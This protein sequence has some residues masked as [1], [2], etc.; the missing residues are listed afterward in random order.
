M[1]CGHQWP[2]SLSS[3]P[4]SCAFSTLARPTDNKPSQRALFLLLFRRFVRFLY[5]AVVSP[6]QVASCLVIV[7]STIPSCVLGL[8]GNVALFP[9]ILSSRIRTHIRRT[10]ICVTMGRR[11]WS[12]MLLQKSLSGLSQPYSYL[13]L[14]LRPSAS[15]TLSSMM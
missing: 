7:P 14:F 3:F 5:L 11:K 9:F 15:P 13:H 8:F 2:H 12:H 6:S 1:R 4:R 10:T